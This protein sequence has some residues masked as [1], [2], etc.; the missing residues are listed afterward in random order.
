MSPATDPGPR[1]QR[2]AVV[3]G[4]T[5]AVGR[6]VCE[7]LV[8]HGTRTAMLDLNEQRLRALRA[9]VGEEENTCFHR[10]DV[11]DP[12]DLVEA[13]DAVLE[14]FGPPDLVV[15]G[16][17]VL[18]AAPFE[19]AIPAEWN[20]MLE[21]NIKALLQTAQTFSDDLLSTARQGWK[22]DLVLMGSAHALNRQRD[23]AVFSAIATAIVQL[24]RHLRAEFG[25][26]GVRVHYVAPYFT[27]SA[28]GTSP[29]ASPASAAIHGRLRGEVSLVPTEHVADLLM[30]MTGLPARVNLAEV[31][32]SPTE[33]L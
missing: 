11:T 7:A 6:A 13:R 10:T 23:Y 12:F 18:S 9:H 17:G 2:V 25:E 5:G 8:A 31:T 15:V 4:A 16:A 28:A 21:T 27:E 19:E 29:S 26:R 1:G 32:I 33:T 22:A 24:S 14:K 20:A 3:T 30:F